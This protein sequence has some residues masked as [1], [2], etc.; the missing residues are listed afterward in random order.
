MEHHTCTQS[1]PPVIGSLR[2]E[3]DLR[4]E[5]VDKNIWWIKKKGKSN[6]RMEQKENMAPFGSQQPAVVLN[7]TKEQTSIMFNMFT[8]HQ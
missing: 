4:S 2:T 6:K 3:A 1:R 5:Q 7:Q 8:Q